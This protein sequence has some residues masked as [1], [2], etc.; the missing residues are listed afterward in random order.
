M[1]VSLVFNRVYQN[2]ELS[3]T[4]IE[5]MRKEVLDY[6]EPILMDLY[7]KYSFEARRPG[8]VNS[9]LADLKKA[10]F[11]GMSGVKLVIRQPKGERLDLGVIL[12]HCRLKIDNHELF[13]ND[14]IMHMIIIKNNKAFIQIK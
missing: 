2:Y 8:I 7:A 11:S 1:N 6:V 12:N 14:Y 13:L 10:L 3:P 9:I 5:T 4:E